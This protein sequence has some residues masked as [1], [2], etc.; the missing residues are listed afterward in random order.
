MASERSRSPIRYCPDRTCWYHHRLEL[1][2]PTFSL[3]IVSWNTNHLP[4]YDTS[5]SSTRT[6]VPLYILPSHSRLSGFT[7][8][9]DALCGLYF[10]IILNC[11]SIGDVAGQSL[12]TPCHP[13]EFLSFPSPSFTPHEFT[14]IVDFDR[15]VL[16]FWLP[17]L[18]SFH[19]LWLHLPPSC[20]LSYDPPFS[21]IFV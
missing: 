21:W 17:S 5:R 8:P 1:S 9:R 14:D 18:I 20:S 11:F 6:Q 19:L 2:V 12:W 16:A 3:T 7:I 15:P 13:P 10:N 4:F